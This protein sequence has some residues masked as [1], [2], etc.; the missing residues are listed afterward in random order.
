[1]LSTIKMDSASLLWRWK[2]LEEINTVPL[3]WF[4]GKGCIKEAVGCVAEMERFK[5]Q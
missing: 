5:Y 4:G 2:V 3:T 1:M